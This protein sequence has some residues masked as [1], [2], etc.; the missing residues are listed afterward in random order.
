MLPWSRGTVQV[1]CNWNLYQHVVQTTRPNVGARA[2]AQNTSAILEQ[3]QRA[4]DSNVKKTKQKHAEK[5]TGSAIKS[6]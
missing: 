2:H 1:Y 3:H 5:Y 4:I 6:V